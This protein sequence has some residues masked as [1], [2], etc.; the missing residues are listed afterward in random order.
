MLAPY[1]AVRPAGGLGCWVH[2]VPVQ[3]QVS[4]RGRELESVPPKRTTWP[5]AASYAMLAVYLAGGLVAGL[6]CV[7]VV[8]FQVQVSFRVTM[9][10]GPMLPEEML[11]PPKRTT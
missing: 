5:V 1:L 4:F 7:H 6:S 8:P 10:G 3:V 9:V 2:A 11:T